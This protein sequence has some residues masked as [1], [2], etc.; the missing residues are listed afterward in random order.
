MKHREPLRFASAAAFLVIAGAVAACGGSAG[1][2]GASGGGRPSSGALADPPASGGS[3]ADAA[4]ERKVVVTSTIE[5]RVDDLHAAYIE[6]QSIAR[7]AGGFVADSLLRGGSA[8]DSSTI[9]LRVPASE[10]DAVVARLRGLAAA[11]VSESQNAREVTEEYTDLSSRLANL[12]RTEAQYQQFLARAA[13]LDEVLNVSGR[14]DA[15]RGQIEQTE[16]RIRLLGDLTD[17]AT[18]NVSLT[19]PPA[20]AER[21]GPLEVFAGAWEVSLDAAL[22]TANL[23]AVALVLLL[24]ALVVAPFGLLGVRFGRR[25]APVARKIMDW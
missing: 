11:V 6:V 17:Y 4:I 22:V 5:L 19:L 1:P 25:L 2:D 16:G 24:W 12:R 8:G 15:V 13:T 7:E 3:S 14:L 20:R 10:H 21:A 18:I 9:R 23:L